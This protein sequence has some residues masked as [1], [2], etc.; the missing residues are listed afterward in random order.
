MLILF[1][2]N[3]RR[4]VDVPMEGFAIFQKDNYITDDFEWLFLNARH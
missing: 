3:F 2:N 1:F 4:T